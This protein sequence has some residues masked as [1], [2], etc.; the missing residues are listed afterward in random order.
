MDTCYGNKLDVDC[1]WKGI[2]IELKGRYFQKQIQELERPGQALEQFYYLGSDEKN[3]DGTITEL[4]DW[5]WDAAEK[6]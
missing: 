3:W 6:D 5:S 1:R 2:G 4:R